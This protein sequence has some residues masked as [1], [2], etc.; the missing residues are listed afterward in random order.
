MNATVK[1]AVHIFSCEIAL[2]G[3][4]IHLSEDNITV[5]L[6]HIYILAYYTV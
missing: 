6:N 4:A 1:F 5:L 2:V 3:S